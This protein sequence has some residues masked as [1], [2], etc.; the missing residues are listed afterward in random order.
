MFA[1]ACDEFPDAWW[2][3]RFRYAGICN[4]RILTCHTRRGAIE[5]HAVADSPARIMSPE[6]PHALPVPELLKKLGVCES[7][8]LSDKEARSRRRKFGPNTITARRAAS[9]LQLLFHQFTSPVVYLLGAAGALAF[10]FGELEEAGAIIAVLAINTLIGFVTELKAAR[11]IEALRALGGRSVR[12]RREGRVSLVAAEELVTGDIVL[13]D[14]GDAVSA[15][16]RLIEASRLAADESMLTGESVTV[17]KGTQPVPPEARLGDGVSML[18][19]GTAITRG[20]SYSKP[21]RAARRL[22]ASSRGCR[23]SSSGRCWSW[24]QR[25]PPSASQAAEIRS[26]WSKRPSRLPWRL[27]P[28]ASRSWQPSRSRGVCGAWPGRTR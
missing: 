4:F 5:H 16:L 14:A 15:D 11:S 2:R 25:L 22:S 8:G 3:R 27:F 9:A 18:F 10:Y 6:S 7:D 20:S 17:D 24:W 1:T 23:R 28:R 13:L 21:M 26:S 19:K 12:V